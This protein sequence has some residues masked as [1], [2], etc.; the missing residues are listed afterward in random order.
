MDKR[1][2]ENAAEENA[3]FEKLRIKMEQ[4][5]KN[6]RVTIHYINN[7]YV[8]LSATIPRHMLKQHQQLANCL[9]TFICLIVVLIL[10]IF[11]LYVISLSID[12]YIYYNAVKLSPQDTDTTV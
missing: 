9:Q 7:A 2:E 6:K 10:S 8:R 11:V 3:A 1:A 5:E 4:D 12:I